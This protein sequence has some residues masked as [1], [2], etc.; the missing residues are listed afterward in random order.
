MGLLFQS[1]VAFGKAG[2]EGLQVLHNREKL[3]GK[4][5]L[6]THSMGRSWGKGKKMHLVSWSNVCKGKKY[7]GLGMRRL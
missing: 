2:L 3:Q 5:M 7:E 6:M 1:H 4:I